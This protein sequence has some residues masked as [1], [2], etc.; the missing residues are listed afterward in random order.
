MGNTSI[1]ELQIG[2]K[3]IFKML[4]YYLNLRVKSVSEDKIV[5]IMEIGM[6]DDPKVSY[7]LFFNLYIDFIKIDN[8]WKLNIENPRYSAIKVLTDKSFLI[9]EL[10][11]KVENLL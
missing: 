2:K 9:K 4:K 1:K 3:Y 10:I 5:T 7:M 6:S 8:K 11:K